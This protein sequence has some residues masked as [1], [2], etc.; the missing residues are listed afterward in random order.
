MI[1][2]WDGTD[3]SGSKLAAYC[4]RQ[5]ITYRRDDKPG[6]PWP[7]LIDLPGGG[8]EAGEDPLATGLRELGEEFSLW[9]PPARITWA[10]PFP[11]LRAGEGVGWF[12]ALP[13]TPDE[14]AAISFGDEGQCWQMLDVVDFLAATDA[15]G[16][17]QAR[18]RLWMK[19]E[20]L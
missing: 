19:D 13:I 14:V 7:G 17:L 18:V 20:V 3:F 6:I 8:R 16:S 4:G 15:V 10:R 11:S 5:L 1:E 12:L 9:L 2:P